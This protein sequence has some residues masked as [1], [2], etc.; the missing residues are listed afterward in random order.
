MW[1]EVEG[2]D[3]RSTVIL[4]TNRNAS[5]NFPFIRSPLKALLA[6]STGWS[7]P[8]YCKAVPLAHSRGSILPISEDAF[9][10]TPLSCTIKSFQWGLTC[11]H[12]L[13]SFRSLT[14][15]FCLFSPF[16]FYLFRY[17]CSHL[18]DYAYK[19]KYILLLTKSN[20]CPDFELKSL[21]ALLGGNR[22]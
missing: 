21:Q 8:S 16:V 6:L 10:H 9:F 14:F 3:F 11:H 18:N 17:S 22:G 2:V 15:Y 20:F 4:Q 12:F 7:Q 5:K 19:D 1:G 13:S